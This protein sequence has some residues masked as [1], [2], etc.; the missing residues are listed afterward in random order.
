MKHSLSL[1]PLFSALAL[2][3]GCRTTTPPAID[4]C[5]GDGSGGAD[6]ILREN[7]RLKSSCVATEEG[8]VYCP[9]S[10]LENMWM[11]TPEDMA[12]YSRWCYDT[13]ASVIRT[14]MDALET[15]AKPKH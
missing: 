10:V 2:L 6:C 12:E 8:G 5:I 9:P 7:S 15:K 13:N 1:V 4:I 14:Q 3:A 11:T